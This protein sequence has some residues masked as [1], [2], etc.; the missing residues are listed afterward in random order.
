MAL[1]VRI[2]ESVTVT[3]QNFISEVM[4]LARRCLQYPNG[5][6]NIISATVSDGTKSERW[7]AHVGGKK[8]NGKP[9]VSTKFTCN[10]T[11]Y[12]TVFWGQNVPKH[13]LAMSERELIRRDIQYTTG[14]YG[15]RWDAELRPWLESEVLK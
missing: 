2:H 7:T 12:P 5:G 4:A 1:K 6:S 8:E 11:E 10:K 15:N 13:I 3:K 14:K 9:I